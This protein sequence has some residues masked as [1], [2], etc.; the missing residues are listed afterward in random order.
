MITIHASV[1]GFMLLFFSLA[2]AQPLNV[3]AAEIDYRP[4]LWKGNL[5]KSVKCLADNIYYEAG[6]QTKLGKVAVAYTTLNRVLHH[7][8]EDSICGVVYERTSTVCQFSWVCEKKRFKPIIDRELIVY[9]ESRKVAI[10]VLKSYNVKRDPTKGSLFYHANYVD[11]KWKK[12]KTIQI[13][14]HIF[15]R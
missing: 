6:N 3:D 1:V 4:Y 12:K 15:Y 10:E 14:D 9:M 2:V 7:D 5:E 13:Q 8:F 11:P